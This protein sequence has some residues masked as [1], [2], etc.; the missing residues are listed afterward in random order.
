MRPEGRFGRRRVGS[1]PR[2]SAAAEPEL[3]C[4]TEV[5]TTATGVRQPQVTMGIIRFSRRS[6]RL[7]LAVLADHDRFHRVEV[8]GY[9]A[10]QP[11]QRAETTAGHVPSHANTGTAPA[12][13]GHAPT[14]VQRMVH[15]TERRPCFHGE[16][17][18]AAVVVHR[19]HL[20]RS[21]THRTAGS[22]TSPSVQWPPAAHREALSGRDDGVQRQSPPGPC[23]PRRTRCP[24]CRHSVGC[25]RA[26][27]GHGKADRRDSLPQ[28]GRW[29][30]GRG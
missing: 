11:R 3:R 27:A 2:A 26:A 30:C 28:S 18:P 14:H 19:V 20:A 6:H 8:V 17:A 7:R 24:V 29:S 9:V 10:V 22:S 13:Q 25:I 4:H 1:S 16:C 21:I 5:P 23:R 15:T 12:G